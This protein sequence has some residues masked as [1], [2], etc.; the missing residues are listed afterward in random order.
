MMMSSQVERSAE[1][2]SIR[3]GRSAFSSM[4]RT[5]TRAVPSPTTDDFATREEWRALGFFYVCNDVEKEWSFVGSRRGL[6]AL[7]D[8][9]LE[10]SVDS[11]YQRDGKHR[12]YGPHMYFEVLTSNSCGID[13]F[14]IHGR[15]AE[16]QRLAHLIGRKLATATPNTTIRIRDE[17]VSP[18]EFGI[19]LHLREDTFDPSSFDT[20]LELV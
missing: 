18:C 17:F 7:R 12:S 13:D 20:L 4:S 11:R 1:Q 5:G 19:A 6:L 10:Y 16:L 15:S 8:L 3:Q 14:S 9:L 2:V